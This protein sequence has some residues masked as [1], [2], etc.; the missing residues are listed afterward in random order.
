MR[1]G[2]PSIAAALKPTT[3]SSLFENAATGG[4]P[5]GAAFGEE[6]GAARLDVHHVGLQDNAVPI[7]QKCDQRVDFV[8]GK[9]SR[10]R[11]RHRAV[12]IVPRDRRVRVVGYLSFSSALKGP[13]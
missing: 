12:D 5:L 9:R 8:M 13:R 3:K 2:G 11:D 1:T 7:E 10:F 4:V 6:G